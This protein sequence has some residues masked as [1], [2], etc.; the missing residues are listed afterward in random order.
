MMVK[1]VLD[2]FTKDKNNALQK[3]GNALE[4]KIHSVQITVFTSFDSFIVIVQL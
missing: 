3:F 2:H 1:Y 4:K